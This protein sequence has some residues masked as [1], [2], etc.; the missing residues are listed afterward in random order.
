MGLAWNWWLDGWIIVAGMLCALASSTIGAFLVLRRMSLLGDAISHTVLPGL[1]VAFL[2]SN[3]RNSIFM[4]IGAVI[5]GILTAMSTQWIRNYGK[6]DEGASMG[7][8]F[9]SLFALGLV[10]IVQ[11]ADHVDLDPGCI[12]YGAIEH[13]PIDTWNIAGY[14][15]PRV[16]VILSIVTAINLGFILMFFKELKLSSF[17]P[18]LATTTGFNATVMHYGLMTLVAITSVACFE[19]VGNILVIAMMIVPAATGLL[20][21]NRLSIVLVLSAI[22]GMVAAVLGHLGAVYI[23]AWFGMRST[24]TAGMMAVMVGF[25]FMLVCLFAPQQGLLV[26][27][28]RDRMLSLRILAEDVIALLYRDEERGGKGI[29]VAHMS[30]SLFASRWSLRWVINLHSRADRIVTTDRYVTLT[31]KGRELARQLVRSHRLWENYLTDLEVVPASRVHAKAERL[32]HFT[33]D[34]MRAK[35]AAENRTQSVDPHGRQIPQ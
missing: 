9:T 31:D 6:V 15:I 7:V 3:S 32:E 10:L 23:P 28:V 5:V 30:E 17:D 13:T 4:F 35:L 21:S 12:L 8:V 26:R 22:I 18:A 14:E 24:T 33:S 2:I 29:S 27:Y 25:I 19:S 20:L 1:A 16:V 11:A 34:E